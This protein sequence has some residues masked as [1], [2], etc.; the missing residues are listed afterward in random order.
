[1]SA[2]PFSRSDGSQVDPFNAGEP[3]L[4]GGDPE[5]LD[6][7]EPS[8]S[9]D[10]EPHGSP[11]GTPHKPDDDY[12]A[13]VTRDSGYDA[14]ST[15]EP[16]RRR[17]GKAPAPRRDRRRGTRAGAPSPADDVQRRTAK[18]RHVVTRVV[19]LLVLLVSFGSSIVS[20]AAG[21]LSAAG[22]GAADVVESLGDV[23]F[24]GDS[25]D[26]GYDPYVPEQDESELAAT[27]ALQERL[28]QIVSAQGQGPT[29]EQVKTYFEQKVLDVEGR[30]VEELGVDAATFA[31]MVTGHLTLTAEYAYD[32]GDG[33]ATAYAGIGAVDANSL[34]WA[35]DE[36]AS[37]YLFEHDLW[38]ADVITPTEEQ[39]TYMTDALN[40]ALDEV[41]D[42]EYELSSYSFD[43][44][45]V[46]DRWV[47][48]EE[49]LAES[50]EMALS[51]Y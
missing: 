37:D 39:R 17:G 47:V 34:F 8:V 25:S 11:T 36:A 20:C 28:D 48:D 38:G 50:M 22:D 41:F 27:E 14:P 24:D 42:G 6:G 16:R 7:T 4:P 23:L 18:D 51:L 10:Y 13:P 49:S 44:E 33:T 3:E 29:Y 30:S 19:V 15:D 32:W 26:D 5:P 40:A 46:D 9:H 2:F 31:R 12:R 45:L 1:M 35:F 43:L 21:F